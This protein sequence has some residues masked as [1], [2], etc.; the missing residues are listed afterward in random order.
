VL[1]AVL[2][3]VAVAVILGVASMVVV[4]SA[5]AAL[6]DGESCE[7]QVVQNPETNQLEWVCIGGETDPG[8]EGDPDDDTGSTNPTESQTCTFQGKEIPCNG[9]E[10]SVW[11]GGCY[12]GPVLDPQPS[13]TGP[14]GEEIPTGG[15][16]HACFQAPGFAGPGWTWVAVGTP[17]PVDPVQVA[18]QAIAQMEL[19]A[20]GVGIVPESGEDKEGLIGLPTWMWVNNPA[21]NTYGP[22]T[23]SATDGPVT[24]T[25]TAK[26]ERVSWDMGDGTPTVICGQGTPYADSY[27]DADSPTCGHRYEHVSSDQPDGVYKV[28]AT[29]RWVI[30]WTGAGM[31][32]TIVVNTTTRRIPIRIGELQVLVQ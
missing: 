18:Y 8:E 4:L 12:V 21:P 6:A 25:A 13:E 32:G 22:I 28:R 10:G 1:S 20:I 30:E 11:N 14:N 29:S 7:K 19:R 17:P 15:Q 2:G 24:V 16:W 23:T 3:R 26:V 9:P 31:G 27:G 5:P